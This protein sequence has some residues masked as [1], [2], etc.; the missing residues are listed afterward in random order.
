MKFH[1]PLWTERTQVTCAASGNCPATFGGLLPEVKNLLIQQ[2]MFRKTALL[3]FKVVHNPQEQKW[4]LPQEVVKL[5]FGRNESKPILR[6]TISWPI[7]FSGPN[8]S[9]ILQTF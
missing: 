9:W 3:Y 1:L 2:G 6:W 7:S 8:C 4:N 5:F